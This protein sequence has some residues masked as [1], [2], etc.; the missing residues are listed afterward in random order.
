MELETKE[1]PAVTPAY[2]ITAYDN[3]T[4]YPLVLKRDWREG[5]TTIKMIEL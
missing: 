5:Q 2:K 1:I 4:Y 3:N